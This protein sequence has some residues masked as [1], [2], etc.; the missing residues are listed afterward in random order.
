MNVHSAS[1]PFSDDQQQHPY[2][3]PHL[4]LPNY[5][6]NDISVPILISSFAA[7]SVLVF[8]TTTLLARR[9]RPTIS[10]N[11]LLTTCW[12][13][14]CGCIHFFFEGKT[15]LLTLLPTYHLPSIAPTS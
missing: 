3:P 14:L 5:V 8:A 1:H 7:S 9:M 12:F 13:A 15:Y 6:P 4:E 2:Y 11:E 10:K